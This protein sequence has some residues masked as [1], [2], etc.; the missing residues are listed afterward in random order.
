MKQ[1]SSPLSHRRAAE[2]VAFLQRR[3]GG[4][5][6]SGKAA[7]AIGVELFPF[8]VWGRK[9]ISHWSRYPGGSGKPLILRDRRH[10]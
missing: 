5:A 3:A 6:S 1:A 2:R 8:D 4:L 10:K 9:Q 7:E